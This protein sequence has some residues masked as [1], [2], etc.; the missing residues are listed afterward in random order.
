M[1][2]VETPE[3]DSCLR[4]HT[5][6]HGTEPRTGTEC[7]LHRLQS[8]RLEARP[9]TGAN[10]CRSMTIA[11]SFRRRPPG[12]P[13]S[14][15]TAS[16]PCQTP[17]HN[18][19]ARR[20]DSERLRADARKTPLQ[21]GTQVFRELLFG[22]WETGARGSRAA[23]QSAHARGSVIGRAIFV[24]LNVR[25]TIGRDV[26]VVFLLM[27]RRWDRAC[28]CQLAGRSLWASCPPL[29]R[30]KPR[31]ALVAPLD[32][33]RRSIGTG[34]GQGLVK[35]FVAVK[36]DVPAQ[37]VL[38][39]PAV[40]QRNVCDVA[41]P[42]MVGPPLPPVGEQLGHLGHELLLS[43]RHW[44]V[45]MPNWLA[46]WAVVRSPLAAARATLALNGAPY[47]RRLPGIVILLKGGLQA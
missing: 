23:H 5:A 31:F 30:R 37:R 46:S 13:R 20:P 6:K 17:G 8:L 16:E 24:G 45:W 7:L 41:R 28:P 36:V 18:K 12:C 35:P 39:L 4:L 11:T 1:L 47:T 2:P 32:F 10:S 43:S 9:P 21:G 29:S 44:L 25:V 15:S 14:T 3:R 26:R 22:G 42:D 33:L 38:G 34:T 40:L 19:P 27:S